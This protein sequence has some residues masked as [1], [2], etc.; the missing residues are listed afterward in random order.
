MSRLQVWANDEHIILPS[1]DKF[2]PNAERISYCGAPDPAF[3]KDYSGVSSMYT[4]SGEND[5]IA[6]AFIA[7]DNERY[8]EEERKEFC[9]GINERSEMLPGNQTLL[10]LRLKARSKITDVCTDAEPGDGDSPGKMGRCILYPEDVAGWSLTRVASELQKRPQGTYLINLVP[11]SFKFLERLTLWATTVDTTWFNNP[12][13]AK[14]DVPAAMADAYS[15]A[16]L[17]LEIFRKFNGVGWKTSGDIAE[18]MCQVGGP[19]PTKEDKTFA[20]LWLL[21]ESLRVREGGA[22]SSFRIMALDGDLKDSE[23]QI[24]TFTESEVYAGFPDVNARIGTRGLVLKS[25]FGERVRLKAQEMAPE[26]L[27]PRFVSIRKAIFNGIPSESVTATCVRIFSESKV[28]MHDLRFVQDVSGCRQLD[29]INRVPLVVSGADARNSGVYNV[30]AVGAPA[31]VVV[32]GQ[33]SSV[34]QDRVAANVDVDNF[35]LRG[36]DTPL[37]WRQECRDDGTLALECANITTTPGISLAMA[38]ADGTVTVEDCPYGNAEMW[39]CAAGRGRTPPRVLVSTT[40]GEPMYDW[41][42][43]LTPD[44]NSTCNTTSDAP[45]CYQGAAYTCAESGAWEAS[46]MLRPLSLNESVGHAADHLDKKH[47]CVKDNILALEHTWADQPPCAVHTEVFMSSGVLLR[48]D[49]VKELAAA[50][51][52]Y[53]A[54]M[55]HRQRCS[56][57]GCPGHNAV[58]AD[59]NNFWRCGLA[60][61]HVEDYGY[62]EWHYHPEHRGGISAL[63]PYTNNHLE[64]P[65][66]A[67]IEDSS[68]TSNEVQQGTLETVYGECLERNGTSLIEQPCDPFSSAQAWLFVRLGAHFRLEVPNDPF[69]CLFVEKSANGTKTMVPCP[70]C[71]YGSSNPEVTMNRYGGQPDLRR[72]VSSPPFPLLEVPV[73]TDSVNGAIITVDATTGLCKC[74]EPS[75]LPTYDCDCNMQG[76]R[77]SDVAEQLGENGCKL[78]AGGLLAACSRLGAGLAAVDGTYRNMRDACSLLNGRV[79]VMV[80]A[81]EGNG[82]TVGCEN[83]MLRVLTLGGGYYPRE[84][85]TLV[86]RG[87]HIGGFVAITSKIVYQPHRSGMPT[88]ITA[89]H[90][91]VINATSFLSAFGEDLYRI[92]AEGFSPSGVLWAGVIVEL[93][94]CF[95]ALITHLAFLATTPSAAQEVRERVTAAKKGQ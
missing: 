41:A 66:A 47:P 77:K 2:E 76:M 4:L 90:R 56:T 86:H 19:G 14:A 42:S 22:A 10:G 80:G 64:L 16:D 49:S 18:S 31:V 57:L 53:I 54:K 30:E 5:D 3:R 34:F 68:M 38:R 73:S 25:A 11:V 26:R 75:N 35:L 44:C 29:S 50:T 23:A 17:T 32:R 91:L 72:G 33:D 20:L 82:A 88:A 27:K 95:L 67:R 61:R 60:E 28:D 8:N 24:R 79:G 1:N 84:E 39:A 92:T 55:S 78:A 40:Q 45:I 52:V 48:A 83:D 62:W 7:C 85:L 70:P 43:G 87:K 9:E 37:R 21:V 81:Q 93:V 89:P 58:V 65:Y 94:V 12:T 69:L 63:Q 51:L 6:P 15:D 59:E 74:Y 36:F 13:P 71:L 46:H